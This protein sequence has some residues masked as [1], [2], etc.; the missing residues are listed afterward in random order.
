MEYNKHTMHNRR[1]G[2]VVVWQEI[3]AVVV[4]RHVIVVDSVSINTGVDTN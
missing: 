3:N 2:I 4:A 1:A